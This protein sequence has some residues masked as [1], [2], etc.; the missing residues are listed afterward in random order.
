MDNLRLFMQ[1][2]GSNLHGNF[3]LDNVVPLW[4]VR[5]G[6]NIRGLWHVICEFVNDSRP[7][8]AVVQLCGNDVDSAMKVEYLVEEYLLLAHRYVC[9]C[10][11]HTIIL[12]EALP[13]DKPKHWSTQDYLTRR[14]LF[15]A[16]MKDKLVKTDAK[17]LAHTNFTNE[18]IWFWS[19]EKLQGSTQLRDGVHLTE[20]GQRRLYFSLQMVMR[21]AMKMQ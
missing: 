8:I 2:R 3:K 13:R 14:I 21:E 15:N 10:G 4:K 20:K 11:V 9:Y 17:G 12:C 7:D 5:R 19:H 16:T 6:L 18:A 1:R